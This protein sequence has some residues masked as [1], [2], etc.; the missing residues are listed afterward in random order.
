[1]RAAKKPQSEIKKETL[2]EYLARGG[3]VAK[4]P[5]GHSTYQPR[6]H[7]GNSTYRRFK[8]KTKEK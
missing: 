8:P 5:P 1:M 3:K 7:W 6:T 4:Y 2:E